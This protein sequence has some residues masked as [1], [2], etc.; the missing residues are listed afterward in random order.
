MIACLVRASES[1]IGE[2]L[3]ETR[4]NNADGVNQNRLSSFECIGQRAYLS[5]RIYSNFHIDSFPLATPDFIRCRAKLKVN[6]T[7]KLIL[8]QNVFVK[9]TRVP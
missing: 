5:C 6:A 7:Q 8:L 4:S 3:C 9:E 1:Q 2:P